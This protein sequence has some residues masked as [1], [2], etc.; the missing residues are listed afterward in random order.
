MG[1]LTPIN[2]ALV[3]PS[4]GA[5]LEK[6]ELPIPEATTG[7]VVT[8]VLAAPVLPYT[9]LAHAGLLPQLSLKPPLIPNS[10]GIGRVHAVGPDA[11]RLKP[12]D[13]VY[14]K[15]QVEARDDPRTRIVIGH[16][17]GSGPREKKLMEGE[18]KDGAFQQYQKVPL[19]NCFLLNENRLCKELGYTPAV[20]QS[21]TMYAISAGAVIEAA[22]LKPAETIVI[23]PSGGTF[24][25]LA[26]EISLALGANVIAIGRNEE[27]LAAMHK[28]INHPRLQYVAMTGNDEVDSKA[29]LEKT[30]DGAGAEVYNDW[31]PGELPSPVYLAAASSVLKSEG[32]IVLSGGTMGGLGGINYAEA[33]FKDLQ[34]IAK[35]V[36]HRKTLEQVIG[37]ITQGLLRIGAE[38]GTVTREFTL[39]EAEEAKEYARNCGGWRHYTVLSP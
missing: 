5:P 14:V 39:D 38:S 16:I 8:R 1:D 23:G 34:I 27:K 13:L 29:I 25:G 26:L 19:E 30:P 21:L 10:A 24:G 32:R 35:W 11:V 15:A 20:L 22:D 31:T 6:V 12:G 4:F 28:R 7:T 36:C 37:M 3:L 18:W 9:H 17:G 2:L 33:V